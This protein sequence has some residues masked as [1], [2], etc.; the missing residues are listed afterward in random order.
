MGAAE[1]V[2]D[3]VRFA[4]TAGLSKDVID[5]LENKASLLAEQVSALENENTKLVRENRSLTMEN[6]QLITHFQSAQPK[7]QEIDAKTQEI[8]K[9]L[10][11]QNG[12]VAV[13]ELARH[14]NLK[15]NVAK[16]H[17]EKLVENQYVMCP[18][19][20]MGGGGPLGYS[21]T[22]EGRKFIMEQRLES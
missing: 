4:T 5:L 16:Y 12:Q 7:E 15:V 21:I 13:S 20:V 9:F 3:L 10:F 19:F 8:L 6:Q 17:L 11:R 14:F 2:R 22:G 18:G 1:T